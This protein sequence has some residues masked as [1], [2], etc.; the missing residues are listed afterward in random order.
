MKIQGVFV[1]VAAAFNHRGELWEVKIRH[2]AAK[3]ARTTIAGF[4]LSDR[5]PLSDDER[6]R[7]R[8]WIAETAPEKTLLDQI[9]EGL[10]SADAGFAQALQAGAQ[11]VI[12]TIA[13]AAPYAMISIWEAHRTR[14][15]EAAADWQNRLA[16]GIAAIEGANG[17]AA[18]K[19]AM[20]VNGYYGGP[21]RLPATVLRPEEKIAVERAFEGIRG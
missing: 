10:Y 4:A 20:D 13:N 18:L 3:W 14:D 17:I 2:N 5:E 12:S 16:A 21:P 11:G 7:M 9:P 19:H 6:A 8:Q 15:F 1:S